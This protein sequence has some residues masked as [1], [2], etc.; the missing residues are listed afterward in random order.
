MKEGDTADILLFRGKGAN[1][2]IQR[3][4]TGSEYDHAAVL[5]RFP[6]GTLYILEA[7]GYYGVGLCSWS[8]L[9]YLLKL[10]WFKKNGM[11]SMRKLW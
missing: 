7:T 11:N 6:S 8:K 9:F 2:L 3:A 5:L 4:F 1:C 10:I